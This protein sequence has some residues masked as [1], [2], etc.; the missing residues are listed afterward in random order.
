MYWTWQTES[1]AQWSYRKGMDAGILPKSAVSR[2]WSCGDAVP[3]FAEMGLPES[4]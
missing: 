2:E 3:D 4:Y 1:A